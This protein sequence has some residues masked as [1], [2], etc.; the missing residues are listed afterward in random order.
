VELRQLVYFLHVAELG[1]F[2]R[3]QHQLSIAQPALSRQIRALEDELHQ[4]LFERNGRGVVPTEAGRQLVSYAKEIVR[5]VESARS[6]VSGNTGVLSG[7]CRV[8][9]PP[10][11]GSLLTLPIVREFAE[12]LPLGHLALF[13]LPS[14]SVLEWVAQGRVDFGLVQNAPESS[15]YTLK[16]LASEKL[17]L[18]GPAGEARSET[19]PI[20]VRDIAAY[21]LIIPSA[22]QSRLHLIEAE[23]ARAH[24]TLNVAW[25]VGSA[26][27]I[28]DLVRA[29]LGSAIL[30]LN[31]LHGRREQFIA[32]KI[33]EPEITITLSLAVPTRRPLTRLAA[34]VCE[35]IETLLPG[36]VET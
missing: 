34:R 10:S 2:T 11:T 16:T 9:L 23:M 33:V 26:T 6:D 3:A 36:L 13:E 35:M 32:R 22:R 8:A 31:A 7:E 17:H 27:A 4:K 5:I 29:G 19:Q 21:P 28:L 25:E 12:Q 30:S 18:I 24:V 15:S 14:A 20:A 1:S